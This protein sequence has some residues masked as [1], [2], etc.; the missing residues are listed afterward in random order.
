MH[1]A[2]GATQRA[3]MHLSRRHLG[4][5][6]LA[7]LA[8]LAA[9]IPAVAAAADDALPSWNDGPTKQAILAF[10]AGATTPGPSFVSAP[11]RIATFDNDGTLW[12]EQPIYVEFAFALDRARQLAQADPALVQRPAFKAV[13]AGDPAA[14]GALTEKELV[15]L[16]LA[17]HTNLTDEAF[18]A[19]AKAWLATARHPRFQRPY[20]E[21]VYQPQLEL[22]AHLR[23]NGFKTFIVSGG[24]VDFM[25]AFAEDAYGVPPEQ[26]IGSSGKTQFQLDGDKAS[27]FK[28]PEIGSVDDG[29]GKPQN[30]GLAIGRRPIVAVGN[31]DG[32]LPMLQY[33]AGG[34][35]PALTLLVHHDDAAREYAYD[36]G[37]KV[38]ALDKAWDEA[39]RRGW[40]L[41]S[42]R[43][44]W[45]T[46]SP[47]PAVG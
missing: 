41:I 27:L 6:S 45:K 5:L 32:D 44:D 9:R 21:L 8:S 29:P 34:A 22:L 15:E 3:R 28:L 38:G 12:C 4:A 42:M 18:I 16:V 43:R 7:T 36:R 13:V 46:V 20:A 19:D 30:I 24:G 10:I 14:I 25:R 17:T 31:S 40:P 47:P 26:V 11:E 39:V 23:A 33:A 37:S 35:R 2:P 1:V